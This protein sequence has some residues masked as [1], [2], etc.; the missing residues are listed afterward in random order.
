MKSYIL[1]IFFALLATFVYS[2]KYKLLVYAT[3]DDSIKINRKD[4]TWLN[5]DICI[6]I[7]IDTINIS[8]IK[9]CKLKGCKDMFMYNDFAY[10]KSQLFEMSELQRIKSFNISS[11]SITNLDGTHFDPPTCLSYS[12][13]LNEEQKDWLKSKLSFY[14][15]Y[16]EKFGV[17]FQNIYAI[18]NLKNTI[19][20]NNI[21]LSESK[22]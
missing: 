16:N 21:I 20:M 13:C 6:K 5:N 22:E 15:R 3:V 14:I 10:Y 7:N 18:D 12:T 9:R 4:T 1:F 8:K 11:F 17:F 19:Q 2:Q